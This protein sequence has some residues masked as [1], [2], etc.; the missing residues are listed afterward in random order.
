MPPMAMLKTRTKLGHL[1]SQMDSTPCIGDV[2][3]D[4]SWWRGTPA[5]GL[6]TIPPDLGNWTL[7]NASGL[8]VSWQIVG[9]VVRL[10]DH[11]P[12]RVAELLDKTARWF[13]VSTNEWRIG[14]ILVAALKIDHL[15]KLRGAPRP[16]RTRQ[17]SRRGFRG[18][19]LAPRLKNERRPVCRKGLGASEGT[20]SVK[21]VAPVV[22][23][24]WSW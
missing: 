18:L 17:G 14:A 8:Y 10:V 21:I 5:L 20:R 9:R 19:E 15:Q 2:S 24:G 4:P 22:K 1:R 13:A 11:H 16:H 6:G 3:A 7:T 23:S 12:L